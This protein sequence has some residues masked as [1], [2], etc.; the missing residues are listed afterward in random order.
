MAAPARCRH[1]LHVNGHIE[2]CYEGFLT[3]AGGTV[4]VINVYK[5]TAVIVVADGHIIE[6]P[7]RGS[8]RVCVHGEQRMRFKLTRK[9]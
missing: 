8:H 7:L 9:S 4:P 3:E 6:S 2:N 5:L 1:H